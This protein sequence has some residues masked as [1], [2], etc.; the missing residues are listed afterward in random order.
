MNKEV[1]NLNEVTGVPWV[2][3]RE[4]DV[5]VLQGTPI[6]TTN[7]KP[8][9]PNIVYLGQHH[10]TDKLNNYTDTSRKKWSTNYKADPFA[11]GTLGVDLNDIGELKKV[12]VS[13]KSGT[14][15]A[16]SAGAVIVEK[17]T[18]FKDAVTDE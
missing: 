13:S 9:L 4:Y 11:S 7:K 15:Q 12:T 16:A 17:S 6:S 5:Y 18:E 2:E 14:A 3:S 8:T 10:L 1:S